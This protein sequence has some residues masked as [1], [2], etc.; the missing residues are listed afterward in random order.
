MVVQRSLPTKIRFRSSS[1][2]QYLYLSDTVEVQCHD[3][4]DE[5]LS[6]FSHSACGYIGINGQ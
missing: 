4:H 2:N 5:T 1:R 6:K 3:V